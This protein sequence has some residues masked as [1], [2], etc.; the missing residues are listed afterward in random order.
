MQRYRVDAGGGE[1]REVS[2]RPQKLKARTDWTFVFTDTTVPPLP[3]GEPRIQVVVGGNEVT[4]VSRFVY[5]PD[6]WERQQRA[7]AT[8]N[9]AL[10]ILR[11]IVFGGVLAAAAVLGVVAWSRRRYSPKL[12]LAAMAMMLVATIANAANGWPAVL[13]S[14][15]TE[16]PLPL[17]IL[18]LVG[19]G[20]LAL[21]I[22]SSLVG[23][24]IGALPHRLAASGRLADRDGLRLGVALGLVAAA[25]VLGASAL[26]TPEWAQAPPVAPLGSVVPWLEIALD[27][28]PGLLT[29]TA[30]MLS[31]LA[32]V[33]AAS[34]G[35]TRRRGFAA[36]VLL[37][38][39]FLAAGA[40][41]GIR[42][43][44]WAVA[45]LVTAVTLLV[46]Y[47]TL[48]R[49]DLSIAV[50]ALGTMSAVQALAPGASRPF[51][52]ALPASFAGAIVVALIAWWWF[53][54]LRN[55]ASEVRRTAAAV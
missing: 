54:A 55:A 1:A 34:A 48:L 14:L 23:L 42:L 16:L 52:G 17:E 13:A 20:L 41:Q 22:S 19:V 28:V 10:R 36:L 49:S 7:A 40:P 53:R 51:A 43:G 26:K 46:A 44:G 33:H 29:R 3:K 2:A 32:F 27:P 39:G 6:D 9:Q 8:R 38:V 15:P 45:G 25:S 31:L 18:A 30:V 37:A 11:G 50:L 47:V 35:W 24:A 12:F 4:S 5:V 21:A